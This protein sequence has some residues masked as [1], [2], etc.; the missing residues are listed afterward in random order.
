MKKRK[1]K[2]L[3]KELQY[4]QE[5]HIERAADLDLPKNERKKEKR[6]GYQ[7]KLIIQ[8]LK[9]EIPVK[10]NYIRIVKRWRNIHLNWIKYIEYYQGKKLNKKKA[11]E[12]KE[13]IKKRGGTIHWNKRWIRVYNGVLD[14]LE[15]FKKK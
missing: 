12:I 14:Y 11:K 8:A 4:A 5:I 3:I 1:L 10:E 13:D 6:I 15:K 7:K 9:K 2:D